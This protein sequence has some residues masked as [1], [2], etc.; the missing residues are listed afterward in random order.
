MLGLDPKLARR[1][2]YLAMRLIWLP[3]D[4]P[5]R[6]HKGGR[7]ADHEFSHDEVLYMRCEKAHVEKGRLKTI[8]G[9]KFPDQSLNRSRY[10]KPFDVLLPDPAFERSTKWLFLGILRFA[11]AAVP[12]SIERDGN[13]ICEFRIE[14]DPQ[15]RNYSHTELRV[16]KN[17]SRISP[18]QKNK[19]SK[20]DRK[21]YRLEIMKSAEVICEPLI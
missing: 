9:I 4:R 8:A 6:M 5:R 13:T 2:I 17:G 18:A 14:H 7:P 19:V 11:V 12:R 3:R 20:Q 10:S 21:N 1:A 15:E 16:Y